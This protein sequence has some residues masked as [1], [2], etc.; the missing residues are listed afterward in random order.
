MARTV[1]RRSPAAHLQEAALDLGVKADAATW[2]ERLGGR[3]LPTGAVRVTPRGPGRT[4]RRLSRRRVVGAGRRRRAAAAPLRR[5][6]GQAHRRSLRRA[7]GKTA[8]LAAAGAHGDRRRSIR[9]ARLARLRENLA[10]L[11]LDATSSRRIL[12]TWAPETRFD[13]VHLDARPVRRR[14]AAPPSRHRPDQ[15]PPTRRRPR[16]AAIGTARH[17]PPP[18]SRPAGSSSIAPAARAGGGRGPDRRVPGEPPRFRPWPSRRRRSAASPSDQPDGDLRTLPF[19]IPETEGSR[20][21]GD[22]FFAARLRRTA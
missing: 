8:A 1:P 7:R 5:R 18:G 16:G 12:R 13:G 9:G 22:G 19:Q 10:R 15:G 17:A 3:V 21:G 4:A 6:A 14:H 20:G 2:A 11:R